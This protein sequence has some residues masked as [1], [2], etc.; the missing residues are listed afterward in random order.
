MDLKQ[1]GLPHNSSNINVTTGNSQN[2]RQTPQKT[3]RRRCRS[4]CLTTAP[5]L[6]L[7]IERYNLKHKDPSEHY[8]IKSAQQSLRNSY[9]IKANHQMKMAEIYATGNEIVGKMNGESLGRYSMGKDGVGKDNGVSNGH[10]LSSNNDKTTE[11]VDLKDL[12]LQEMDVYKERLNGTCISNGFRQHQA[13]FQS[14]HHRYSAERGMVKNDFGYFNPRNS[15]FDANRRRIRARSESE[16]HELYT[17]A[18]TSSG[19]MS[20]GRSVS[21]HRTDDVSLKRV[22]E[23]NSPPLD[24]KI[25]NRTSSSTIYRSK[26]VLPGVQGSASTNV[27]VSGSQIGLAGRDVKIIDF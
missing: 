2:G 3:S 21:G 9:S 10:S 13:V 27:L 25:V 4:E 5:S 6:G 11:I 16:P 26:E 24:T 22:R 18:G 12:Y 7:Q 17:V 20:N 1:N 19:A 23:A 8:A 14:G 15:V